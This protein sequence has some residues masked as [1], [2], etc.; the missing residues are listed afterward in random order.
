MA[1]WVKQ[2]PRKKRANSCRMPSDRHMFPMAHA[3]MHIHINKCKRKI[4]FVSHFWSCWIINKHCVWHRVYECCVLVE[5]YLVLLPRQHWQALESSH[6]GLPIP[7]SHPRLPRVALA[8]S[9]PYA[10][11]AILLG[12]ICCAIPSGLW[13]SLQWPWYKNLP[14]WQLEEP[15]VPLVS[16][17]D[18]VFFNI[19]GCN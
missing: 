8:S 11:W 1:Q 14:V 6:P 16:F 5:T 12:N 17:L 9:F 19:N 13:T 15:K 3:H 7:L 10:T 4:E 2:R 18:W